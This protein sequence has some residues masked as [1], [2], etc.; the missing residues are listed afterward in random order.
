MPSDRI[1]QLCALILTAAAVTTCAPKIHR[2]TV[3]PSHVCAGT[4][5][6]L[7][8]QVTGTPTLTIDPPVAEQPASVYRP[9]VT[10]HFVISVK[11]WPSKKPA[12]SEAEVRVFPAPGAPDEVTAKVRCDGATVSGTLTRDTAEW[13]SRLQ[14]T[15]V[16]SGEDREVM[17]SHAGRTARLTP[18]APATHAFEGTSPGGDWTISSPLRPG[19][20]CGAGAAIPAN[21]NVSAELRCGS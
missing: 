9:H 17:V 15:V 8:A 2:F 10:T 11:R 7:D 19:E 12:G 16:E 14:V 13:D 6:K 18:E 1:R 20:T 3:T 5:V 21:L 4:P